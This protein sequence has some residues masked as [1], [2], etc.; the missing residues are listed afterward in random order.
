M[1]EADAGAGGNQKTAD[2]ERWRLVAFRSF[3]QRTIANHEL[4]RQQQECSHAEAKQWRQQQRVADFS[5]LGPINTRGA[6]TA[7]HHGIG[8]ADADDRTDQ[9][10]R[11]RSGKAKVPGAEIPDD[12]RNQKS[13]HHRETGAASNLQY[14][15]DGQQRYDAESDGAAR[16]QNT[17]EI[18]EARPHDGEFSRQRMSVDDGRDSVRS[19]VEAV[20]ELESQRDQKRNEQQNVRKIG[21]DLGAGRIDVD[22]NA[23]GNEQCTSCQDTEEQYHR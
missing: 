8:H 6:V 16:Q 12:S 5:G 13:E 11:A 3:I 7:A 4:E 19:V 9:R 2:P 18:E 23:V 10:V 14:Q 22:V 17:E 20:D 15:F 1:C 21:R